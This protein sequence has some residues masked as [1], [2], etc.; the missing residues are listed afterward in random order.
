MCKKMYDMCGISTGI[1]Y[2][3]LQKN[4]KKPRIVSNKLQQLPL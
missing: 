4:V 1:N 2:H 3:K